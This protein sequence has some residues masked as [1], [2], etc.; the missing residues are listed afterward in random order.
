MRGLVSSLVEHERIKTTLPKA[1]ELRRHV[2]RAITAGR[3]GDVAATRN[4]M[5][6]Y[7]NRE[8]VSKIVNDL[9]TR[10]KER[11]GGYT[12]ILKLGPRPGDGAPMAFIEF[13]DYNSVKT[14][15]GKT[16]KVKTRDGKGKQVIK[17]MTAAERD[18]YKA[19]Q[20][21]KAALAKRKRVRQMQN[22]SRKTNR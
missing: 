18:A 1:K 14:G 22:A 12:R 9:S 6:K 10:F 7:P 19:A 8:T 11:A 17:E 13:V 15:E 4:L 21:E 2:E 5:S 3:K 20:G 16:F